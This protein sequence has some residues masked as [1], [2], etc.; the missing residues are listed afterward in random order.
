MSRAI[1]AALPP[2]L[3]RYTDVA[4]HLDSELGSESSRL[5]GVLHHFEATCREPGMAV[6]VSYLADMLGGFARDNQPFDAWVRTVGRGFELADQGYRLNVLRGGV[7]YAQALSIAKGLSFWQ[8]HTQ[9]LALWFQF[10]QLDFALNRLIWGLRAQVFAFRVSPFIDIVRLPWETFEKYKS[11]VAAG[12]VATSVHFGTTY[13]GQIIIRMPHFLKDLGLSLK[14]VKTWAGLKGAF[15]H[16]KFTILPKHIFWA[17][18]AMSVPSLLNNYRKDIL[19][20]VGGNY[21]GSQLASALT[22]DSILTLAPAGASYGGALGGAKVGAAIGTLIAPGAGT[23]VGGAVGAI[24]GGAV[25]AW[26]TDWAIDKFEVREKAIPW[27]DEHVFAPVARTIS[28]K[29]DDFR[30]WVDGAAKNLKEKFRQLT[31]SIKNVDSDA[32][33]VLTPRTTPIEGIDPDSSPPQ[34]I[35]IP[36]VEADIELVEDSLVGNQEIIS[37]IDELAVERNYRYQR[38]RQDKGETYCNIFVMDLAK[39]FDIPLPEWLDWNSDGIIDKY[40]DANQ[41]TAWLR[42]NLAYPG[43]PEGTPQ[44]PQLGWRK[45]S[46]E[47]AAAMAAQGH[48]VVAGWENVGGIGHM[49]AVRPDSTP[50]DIR[51][52]QAGS[53]NF[54]NGSLARPGWPLDEIEFFIYV[55][56]S[57]R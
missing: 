4:L 25:A 54:S 5:A 24:I 45:I 18:L 47:E 21:D 33:V 36:P 9:S 41:A 3:Y 53:Q 29:V 51:I 56:N 40:L 46:M 32:N 34:Q 38:N 8:A 7:I 16:G 2:T 22:V 10:K 39:Q 26:G 50:E 28:E 17:N 23:V 20:Y 1:S 31:D 55:G 27:L 19:D 35:T 37:A 57:S 15:T 6:R 13:P 12:I 44:G 30:D 14:E 52:A 49:A 43:M 42:G 48:F 11:L